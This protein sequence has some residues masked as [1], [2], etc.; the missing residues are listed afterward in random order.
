MARATTDGLIT[1]GL[2]QVTVFVYS[3]YLHRG[4]AHRA[5]KFHPA[6]EAVLRIACLILTGIR[7]RRWVGVH[8]LHHRHTDEEG[9]DPHSPH[10]HGPW[11]VR[12]LTPLLYFQFYR[13]HRT[14]VFQAASDISDKLPERILG[15]LTTSIPIRIATMAAFVGL[16]DSCLIVLV[17][18][19]LLLAI[20]GGLNGVTHQADQP[21]YVVDS[22]V[23]A[24]VAAGEGLHRY[25]HEM[26][27]SAK[28]HPVSRLDLGWHAIRGLNRIGAV[29]VNG[30]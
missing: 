3:L 6:F 2:L 26:P 15:R 5:I 1:L 9:R 17:T 27:R 19:F 25:H 10:C 8:R 28:F 21:G 16:L 11:I 30:A 13:A 29:R 4:L 7:P 18:G 23:L 12:L 22:R 20:Q 24:V 14:L